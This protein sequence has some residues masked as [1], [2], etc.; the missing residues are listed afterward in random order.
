MYN[1]YR[2]TNLKAMQSFNLKFQ[3]LLEKFKRKLQ[4][5]KVFKVFFFIDRVKKKKAA[6]KIWH[7]SLLH[8]LRLR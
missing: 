2:E 5:H 6:L 4:S 3:I 1:S 8:N 7:F